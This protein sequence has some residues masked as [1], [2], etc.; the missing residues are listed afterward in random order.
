[1][2]EDRGGWLLKVLKVLGEKDVYYA[3]CSA[4]NKTTQTGLFDIES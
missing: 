3:R 2:E 1:M 4:S